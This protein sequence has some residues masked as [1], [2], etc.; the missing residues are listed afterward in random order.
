MRTLALV[1]VASLTLGGCATFR[2]DSAPPICDGKQRRPANPYGSVL[3]PGAP[4]GTPA[5][6][7]KL[8]ATPAA[9]DASCAA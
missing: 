4:P 8:S 2:K 5:A 3:D 6:P 1:L 9:L 7:D